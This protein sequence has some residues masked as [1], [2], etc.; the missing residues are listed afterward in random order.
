MH[1]FLDRSRSRLVWSYVDY[2]VLFLSAPI[3]HSKDAPL[4]W[5]IPDLDTGTPLALGEIFL[6]SAVLLSNYL[7]MQM[8][9]RSE[10]FETLCC[11]EYIL[12]GDLGA[13]PSILHGMSS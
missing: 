2:Y 10:T 12:R 9:G 5:Q 1:P 11:R 7:S 6:Q 8:M 13:A 3:N 4:V